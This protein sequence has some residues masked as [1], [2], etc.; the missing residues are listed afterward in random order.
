VNALA[1]GTNPGDYTYALAY[2]PRPL[3]RRVPRPQLLRPAT[4]KGRSERYDG[5]LDLSAQPSIELTIEA[6]SLTTDNAR[7]DEHLQSAR[8]FDSANHPQVRFVSQLATLDAERLR[9][10]ASCTL[11]G[12]ASRSN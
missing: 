8:V 2:R 4:V 6:D 5:T 12:R 7:G 1:N 3:H 10:R 11:P 9:V